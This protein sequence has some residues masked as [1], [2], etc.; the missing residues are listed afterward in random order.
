MF[1]AFEK[2]WH[3]GFIF[4]LISV[5]ISNELIESFLR[6]RFQRVALNSQTSEWLL[7]KAGVPQGST[8]GPLFFL[9]TL[10]TYQLV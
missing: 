10:T 1:K 9:F 2:V 7:V 4:K 5:G 6:N 3:E 8:V